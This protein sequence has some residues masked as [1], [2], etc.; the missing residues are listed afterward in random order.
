MYI[1]NSLTYYISMQHIH[2][3]NMECITLMYNISMQHIHITN[4]IEYIILMYNIKKLYYSY[5]H[6]SII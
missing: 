2:T 1:Y 5:I 6:I 3:T 4:T